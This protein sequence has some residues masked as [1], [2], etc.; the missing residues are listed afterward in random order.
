MSDL[1]NP[2]AMPETL[3]QDFMR[4]LSS[5]PS[6][7]LRPAELLGNPIF[8]EEYVSLQV[9]NSCMHA[10]MLHVHMTRWW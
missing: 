9:C 4:M 8:E 2:A 7:R 6:A 3:R 5:N 10:C 1:K